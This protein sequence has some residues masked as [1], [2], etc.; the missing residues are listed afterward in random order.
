MRIDHV[1]NHSRSR[2]WPEK[3]PRA[4]YRRHSKS[5][6]MGSLRRKYGTEM[7]AE[8]MLESLR[9]LLDVLETEYEVC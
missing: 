3:T 7:G 8:L 1:R 2:A 9:S 5:E 4:V 6:N